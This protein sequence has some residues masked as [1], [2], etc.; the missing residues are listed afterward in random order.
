MLLAQ[1]DV[2]RFRKQFADN[3]THCDV[4][5]SN[6]AHSPRQ[7]HSTQLVLIGRSCG[8]A[9][10]THWNSFRPGS[11]SCARFDRVQL[12]V[13]NKSARAFPR[14]HRVTHV[15]KES[16]SLG[17]SGFNMC[18]TGDTT[19]R[20]NCQPA[21]QTFLWEVVHP[22]SQCTSTTHSART[23]WCLMIP[24][25]CLRETNP[26]PPCVYGVC[27]RMALNKKNLKRYKQMTRVC[28]TCVLYGLTTAGA[29]VGN[30]HLKTEF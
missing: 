7:H 28:G 21:K 15:R 14:S 5:E 19:T 3:S 18:S 8:C 10:E 25:D 16:W 9:D 12:D 17:V 13:C 20:P 11:K 2:L 30:A 23:L 1:I 27:T 4:V 24:M 29:T 26:E 6:I 22:H